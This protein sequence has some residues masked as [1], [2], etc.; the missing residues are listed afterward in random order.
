MEAF[1]QYGRPVLLFRHTSDGTLFDP[2]S[3]WIGANGCAMELNY[4]TKEVRRLA[5]QF[6][7]YLNV[8][9]YTTRRTVA[10]NVFAERIPLGGMALEDFTKRLSLL[11]NV[12]EKVL[13]ERY[14]RHKTLNKNAQTQE[15]LATPTKD[16]VQANLQSAQGSMAR[17]LQGKSVI[18][19]VETAKITRPVRQVLDDDEWWLDYKRQAKELGIKKKDRK[20]FRNSVPALAKWRNRLE[21]SLVAE[22]QGEEEEEEEEAQDHGKGKEKRQEFS[23]S[24]ESDHLKDGGKKKKAQVDA[25]DEGDIYMDDAQFET[26]MMQETGESS[27]PPL[28]RVNGQVIELEEEDEVDPLL[29]D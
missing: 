16:H 13:T 18:Q 25:D 15:L 23:E 26:F 17:L 3:L 22:E 12:S 28:P 7:P 10:T 29:M 9:P 14:N 5:W 27:Y 19:Q 8:T 20:K 24:D 1:L 6:N 21:K 11:M 2:L 4:V